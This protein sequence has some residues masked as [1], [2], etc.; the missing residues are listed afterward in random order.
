M[1]NH[2]PFGSLVSDCGND[3]GER[4]EGLLD[5]WATVPAKSGVVVLCSALEV[6]HS[7]AK[8]REWGHQRRPGTLKVT[9]RSQPNP[10]YWLAVF[11]D[12]SC[13]LSVFQSSSLYIHVGGRLRITPFRESRLKRTPKPPLNPT[14]PIRHAARAGRS[15]DRDSNYLQAPRNNSRVLDLVARDCTWPLSP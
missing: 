13:A 4:G 2:I 5:L 15:T 8:S 7:A 12:N 14:N 10:V 3:S 6:S 1:V 11:N 9:T